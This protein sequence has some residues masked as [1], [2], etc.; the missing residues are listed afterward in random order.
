MYIQSE[1]VNLL[2][3]DLMCEAYIQHRKNKASS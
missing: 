1:L 3:A 2:V